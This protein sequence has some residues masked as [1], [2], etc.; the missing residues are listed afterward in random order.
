MTFVAINHIL[1]EPHYR[2]TFEHNFRNRARAI[3]GQPGFL[4]VEVFC[5]RIVG[6]AYMI[7]SHWDSEENFT[8]WTKSEAF[9]EG[10]KRAFADMKAFKDRGEDPP[11]RSS[12]KTYETLAGV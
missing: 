11:L 4:G 7:V 10:H 1:C 8:A 9:I 6:E 2:E 3:D 12:M 5:P